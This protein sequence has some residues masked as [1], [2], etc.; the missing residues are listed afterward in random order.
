MIHVGPSRKDLREFP[1]PRGTPKTGKWP[2][3]S[4]S[5][6][7]LELKNFSELGTLSGLCPQTPGI[8]RFVA[9]KNSTSGSPATRERSPS[10]PVTERRW[11]VD[12][13]IRGQHRVETHPLIRESAACCAC[14]EPSQ[15]CESVLA[16]T[17]SP[18][19]LERGSLS[20][21]ARLASF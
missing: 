1:Y 15:S 19:S 6:V 2:M 5:V 18:S 13:S 21:V 4:L 12:Q 14:N 16:V 10:D 17:F 9:G 7:S 11:Q 20:A 8:E 3:D